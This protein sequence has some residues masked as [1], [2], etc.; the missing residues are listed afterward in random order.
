MHATDAPLARAHD[1][2]VG[3]YVVYRR[4]G[5]DAFIR[6]MHAHFELAVWTSSTRLYADAVVAE[7]FPVDIVPV[8]AWSRERCTR[9]FDPDAHDFE[10]TKNLDKVKRRGYPLER[11]LMLDDTPKKLARH[12]GNLV[13]LL[14]FEGDP[15]D[16]ELF[17]LIEYLPT[18]A[19]A[20]N[21]RS[22]EKRD[23]RKA[24]KATAA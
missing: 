20:S 1:F 4:P 3:P 7:L 8:F 15:D 16:V 14:P 5:V 24:R 19:D 17:A 23:W 22:I 18:L 6:G 2:E 10:W 9:R 21:V 11:V 12:Y 13:R